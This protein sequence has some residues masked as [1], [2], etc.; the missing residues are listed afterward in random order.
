MSLLGTGAIWA[1]RNLNFPSSHPPP[2]GLAG[3]FCV[4]GEN[5]LLAVSSSP[6]ARGTRAEGF[7]GAL[8]GF[9]FAIFAVKSF[10]RL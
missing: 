10:G 1:S 8:C 5:K 9:L 6:L 2:E 4:F 3:G 7:L